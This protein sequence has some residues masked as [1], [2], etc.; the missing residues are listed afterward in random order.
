[1]ARIVI[2]ASLIQRLETVHREGIENSDLSTFDMLHVLLMMAQYLDR[3][4]L[5]CSLQLR[6]SD[7]LLIAVRSMPGLFNQWESSSAGF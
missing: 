1:M 4:F 6:P 5:V 7:N 2:S 3:L